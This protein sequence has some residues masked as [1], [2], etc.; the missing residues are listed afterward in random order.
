[1]T[2]MP[3]FGRTWTR[4]RRL[5]QSNRVERDYKLEA[6]HQWTETPCGSLDDP[7][8]T[9]GTTEYFDAVDRDRYDRYAPWLSQAIGFDQFREAKVLEIGYGQGTDLFQF[10]ARSRASVTGLDLSPSHFALASARFRLAGLA[11][12][13]RLH[14]AEKPWPFGDNTFDVVYSFGVLH[15]TPEPEKAITEAHRVLKP[16]GTII[17]GLYHRHSLF[18][19]LRFASWVRHRDWRSESFSESFWRIEAHAEHTS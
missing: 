10:A 1:M 4:N 9:P 19:L 7:R 11:A 18:S 3:R 16:G 13:L 17:V 14:D 5:E 8:L 12:D 6:R 2:R 15:H